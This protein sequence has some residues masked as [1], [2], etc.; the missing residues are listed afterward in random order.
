[1]ELVS[2]F[3]AS[4]VMGFSGAIMPGPLL[5]V[6]INESL[7]RGFVAGPL[8]VLGHALL[9]LLLVSLLLLGFGTIFDQQIVKG[10]IGLVGGG[11]LIW[12]A[13]GMIREARRKELDFSLT[14]TQ[15]AKKMNPVLLGATISASNPYW[16]L[17]W[18]TVGTTSLV[19]AGKN[20]ILG[21]TSFY[22][23]HISSDLIWYSLV[24]GAVATGRRLFT[25][26]IYRAILWVC[27][28]FLVGIGFYFIHS[29]IQ[30]FAA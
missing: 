19:V 7:R 9:E 8:I 26:T 3:L 30:F 12:M 6:T 10:L 1:M 2:I 14:S 23:G 4:L 29:G 27:G 16:S 28:L 22:L 21:S 11:F 5:T 17:W 20:G 25:P 18:A 24:S 15:P 13:Y